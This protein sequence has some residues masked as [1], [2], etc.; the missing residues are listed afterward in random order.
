MS[1]TS[2]E[3]AILQHLRKKGSCDVLTLELGEEDERLD[4]VSELERRGLVWTKPHTD[5]RRGARELIAAI[6]DEGRKGL[7]AATRE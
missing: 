3:V 6:T 2:L 7:E 5:R 1:M 4:A